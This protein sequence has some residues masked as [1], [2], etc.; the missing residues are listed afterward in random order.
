MKLVRNLML[1]SILSIAMSLAAVDP[2]LLSLVPADATV[3]SGIHVDQSKA[4]KFG[5][6][7]LAQMS[8]DSPDMTRF[9][10]ETGFDPRR[11]LTEILVATNG[12]A[13]A[14]QVVVLGKGVFIPSKILSAGQT[15]GASVASYNGVQMLLHG[16]A[17]NQSAVAFLDSSTALMGSP[18]AVKA[19][20]DRRGAATQLD[21][22]VL[23]KIRDLSA[24][25]DAWFLTT[26]PPGDFFGGKM[27]E[28]GVN[29]AMGGGKLF[30]AVKAA[31]G[32]VKF[33]PAQVII[34]GE[35]L[36]RSEQDATALADVIRFVAGLM[37]QSTDPQAQKAVGLLQN[38]QLSTQAST[39]KLSLSMPEELVEKL[40][41]PQNRPAR[42]A[43]QTRKTA[44]LH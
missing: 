31:N 37:Q 21:A 15:A 5:Q 39:L 26:V 2:T 33:T 19:A 18:A 22:A 34:S 29:Q 41:M 43:G 42:G 4:S 40:F 38:L 6:Y 20:I 13:N 8:S 11:D 12:G 9:I 44:S 17:Q 35:A 24:A 32:G 10:T 23:G 16:N 36:T 25:N 14:Q 3:I 1:G 7:V 28:T 30:E 27:G